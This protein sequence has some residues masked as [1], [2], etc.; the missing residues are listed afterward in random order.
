MS[1]HKV[2]VWHN[3]AD[4]YGVWVVLAGRP[5]PDDG[6]TLLAQGLDAEEAGEFVG[7]VADLRI[8]HNLTTAFADFVAASG[9]RPK[10]RKRGG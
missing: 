4:G 10:G 5:A 1:R 2:D 7:N 3:D 9:S 8:R 6:W